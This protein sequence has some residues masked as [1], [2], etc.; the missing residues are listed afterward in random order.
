MS[1]TAYSAQRS[2][3]GQME[4]SEAHVLRPNSAPV[5]LLAVADRHGLWNAMI[6]GSGFAQAQPCDSETEAQHEARR[7]FWK[8]FPKHV[9]NAGCCVARRSRLAEIPPLPVRGSHPT[10][11]FHLGHFRSLA[12]HRHEAGPPSASARKRTKAT[13]SR[14]ARL[15]PARRRVYRRASRR[16]ALLLWGFCSAALASAAA[17]AFVWIANG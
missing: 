3:S 1:S 7:L 8:A 14:Y 12:Q 11:L 2:S 10:V 13:Q 17:I 9:C 6:V 4:F 15:G 16:A 5:R